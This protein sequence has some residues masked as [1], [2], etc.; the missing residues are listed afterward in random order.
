M[1]TLIC[2]LLYAFFWVIP[3]RLNF[4]CR[5][6]G[7]LCLF[8]LHRR[9]GMKM[10]QAECS[11]TSA[12]KI[13]TPRNYPQESIQ[14]SEHGESLKSR[15]CYLFRIPQFKFNRVG[16][17]ALVVVSSRWLWKPPLQTQT[18]V[19]VYVCMY[20][21]MYVCTYKERCSENFP[22]IDTYFQ[23][24]DFSVCKYL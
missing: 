11:E 13:Q 14:Y 6:F 17:S 2:H 20:A 10:D 18:H 9:V 3:R 24:S 4:M 21:C 12:Y 7:T 1:S 5:R 19:C 16:A 8:H 15:I 22:C 23:R